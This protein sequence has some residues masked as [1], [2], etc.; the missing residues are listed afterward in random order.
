MAENKKFEEWWT[1][2]K[3]GFGDGKLGLMRSEIKKS[4]I[5]NFPTLSLDYLKEEFETAFEA[6]QLA[7]LVKT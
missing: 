7:H 4:E 5:P 2:Y 1:K 6:G 3:S